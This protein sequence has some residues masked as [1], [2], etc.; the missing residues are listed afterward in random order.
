VGEWSLPAI[1]VGSVVLALLEPDPDV[2]WDDSRIAAVRHAL[3][4]P[5]P[6]PTLP[7]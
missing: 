5:L 2:V 3:E 7:G 6:P 4:T 1:G